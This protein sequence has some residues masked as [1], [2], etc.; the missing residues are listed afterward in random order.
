MTDDPEDTANIQGIEPEKVGYKNPPKSA[1]FKNSSFLS[2]A[3]WANS[4]MLD[5]LSDC[6]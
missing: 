3:F 6:V 2:R 5:F 1:Q 4:S